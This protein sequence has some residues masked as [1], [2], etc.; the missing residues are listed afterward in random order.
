MKVLIVGS[1]G[2]E[3]ALA[4]KVS[5]SARVDKLYITPGNAGT[6]QFGENVAVALDDVNGLSAFAQQSAIDLVLIG[7]EV[8]LAAGLTDALVKTGVRVFGPSQ[9]AA[10]IETSKAFAKEFMLRHH[11]PTARFARFQ[12]LPDALA[13][14]RQVDYPI[15]IKASGLAAGKGVIV[16]EGPEEARAALE[17]MLVERAF[18][19]AADEILVEERLS[20]EEVSLLAFTDGYTVRPM[21]PAQ[22]HKRLLEG[23]QGPNTGG[24]GAYAP[25][26]ACPPEMV[27]RLV[28]T[29]LQPTVDG[30]REEGCP[31][32]GVLYAG[33]MLTAKGS[34]VLEFNCRFG[35]PET[36]AILPLLQTDLIEI[37]LACSES[38]LNQVE[39]NWKSGAAV[40]IVLAAGGYPKKVETG[41][42]ITGL[43]IPS[44]S[45]IVFHAGT[46]RETDR[47][48]T[49]GGRVLNV[50][51]LG[52][53][54]SQAL[55]AAYTAIPKIRFAGMQY[56]RDI[57]ARAFSLPG[58][59]EKNRSAYAAAGVNIDAGN[60][61]V[62]RMREAVQSTYTP[63]VLAGIGAFGGL[64]DAR[65]LQGM[66]SPVL[67]ASTD[68]IGTKVRLAAAAKRY[69][70][71]GQDIVNHCINDI[72]VQ[73]ARP[74]FFLDYFATA[75]LVPEVAAQVVK[76][77]AAACRAAGC[78]ILGGETAEMPGVYS[79]GEFDIAGTIVGVVERDQI[80]PRND[81]A[82]GD[83]LVG[84]QASGAHTNGYSL[85]RN[86]FAD[87]PL[88]TIFPELDQPLADA[89]LAPHRS[90]LPVLQAAL[91]L[92]PSPIKALAHITGG[93]FLEN[94]PRILP[95]GLRAVIRVGSWPVPPLFRLIQ[96]R[97]LPSEQSISCAEMFRVFNMGVGMVAVIAKDQLDIFQAAVPE[98][99]WLIGTLVKGTKGVDLA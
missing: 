8:S 23:D 86:V 79:P 73:G 28:Q 26:P 43:N 11:I 87:V 82:E 60:E 95:A 77:I 93:G 29:I 61:A 98:G 55:A 24:M 18:G 31:F 45:A 25:A 9:A 42:Q 32:V 91:S 92:Q 30:L 48:L 16:P 12:N 57:A 40:C 4:W 10:Q 27:D 96:K 85:I 38:R 51:G 83:L 41:K 94:I 39:V 37:A 15:V 74:L 7:P 71:L 36:Q 81:L 54:L 17:A 88:N 76:G 66:Q 58:C 1:G 63:S 34:Q 52:E 47:V 90:Y 13:H 22:D 62:D 35:D 69:E 6:E 56:R 19:A 78:T 5:K 53:N 70:S 72:L 80:L 97:G 20:G 99:T 75:Q 89:L 3:H 68:G 59:T 65:A 49:S 46:R 44:E 33:L 14:L 64:L 21:P 2:R 50:T 84:L 67:V